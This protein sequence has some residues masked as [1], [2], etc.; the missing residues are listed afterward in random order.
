MMLVLILL[1]RSKREIDIRTNSKV[2]FSRP[3]HKICRDFNLAAKTLSYK[4]IAK[5]YR[6]SAFN[7]F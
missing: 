7:T 1:N 3:V 4:M 5:A 6:G 2:S